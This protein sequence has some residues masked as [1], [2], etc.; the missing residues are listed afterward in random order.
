MSTKN[1]IC[2]F[3][4]K[5]DWKILVTNTNKY[6]ATQWTP[7]L[8]TGVTPRPLDGSWCP[9]MFEEMKAYVAI[10]IVLGVYWVRSY[11]DYW[12]CRRMCSLVQRAAIIAGGRAAPAGSRPCVRRLGWRQ[13]TV[14]RPQT[15]TVERNRNELSRI[16]HY[17]T[18]RV[19][20]SQRRLRQIERYLPASGPDLTD[21]LTDAE[22]YIKL[23]PLISS[24]CTCSQELAVS[25]THPSVNEMM[26]LLFGCSKHTVH[27]PK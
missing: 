10:V 9:V 17:Y 2:L 19:S 14:L 20:L 22:W 24:I 5:T 27:M 15:L 7:D 3:L 8:L 18:F 12:R 11:S 25:G 16:P 6:A 26:V 1:W 13:R 21:A 23:V 4:T